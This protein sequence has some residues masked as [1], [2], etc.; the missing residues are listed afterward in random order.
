MKNIALLSTLAVLSLVSI[1]ASAADVATSEDDDAKSNGTEW[2]VHTGGLG[3]PDFAGVVHGATLIGRYDSIAFGG[4][5][6]GAASFGTRVGLAATGGWSYRTTSG[7]GF[8][9]LG[10]AGVHRY[11]GIGRGILSD[12]PGVSGTLPFVG[13]RARGVYVF[14]KGARHFQLGLGATYDHD[15]GHVTRTYE[16]QETSWW[17]GSKSTETKTRTVGFDSVGATID[18]GMTFD[19]F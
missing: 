10:A 15:L 12:D 4:M 7:W 9:L 8:D 6:E 18:L 17:D 16:Y 14:G 19:S 1:T 11:D 5:V 3:G 13:A 2:F